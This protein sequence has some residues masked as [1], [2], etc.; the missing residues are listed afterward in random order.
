MHSVFP[1]P[2]LNMHARRTLHNDFCLLEAD[3]DSVCVERSHQL[4]RSEMAVPVPE[5]RIA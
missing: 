2:S 1:Q 3:V 5:G 4:L